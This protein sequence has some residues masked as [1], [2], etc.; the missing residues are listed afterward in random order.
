MGEK[1]AVDILKKMKSLADE[2]CE[3]NPDLNSLFP[4]GSKDNV[5][6]LI[7]DIQRE[8]ETLKV[9]T[10]SDIKRIQDLG[11]VFE[12][13]RDSEV[14]Y[15]HHQDIN[16]DI[17]EHLDAFCRVISSQNPILLV[18]CVGGYIK[19]GYTFTV[20]PTFKTASN[21]SL[22]FTV[23]TDSEL[24]ITFDSKNSPY[25]IPGMMFKSDVVK[26]D[27]HF[28]HGLSLIIKDLAQ[29]IFKPVEELLTKNIEKTKWC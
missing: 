1:S 14:D 4:K 15:L 13:L 29:E 9:C 10:K 6:S 12:T 19:R 25:K 16:N 2:L 26:L 20:E 28:E 18:K 24:V 22:T 21:L 5:L 23:K 3:T 17:K 27:T 11:K 8:L 7:K